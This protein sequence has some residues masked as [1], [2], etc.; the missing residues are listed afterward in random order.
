M[1]A[2]LVLMALLPQDSYLPLKQGQQ[3]TYVVQDVG[4]EAS[5]PAREVVAEVGTPDADPAWVPVSNYLGYRSCWLRSGREGIELK[6][7]AKAD[8][9]ALTILKDSA[10]TGDTWTGTLG[11]EQLTFSL[12]GEDTLER[13]ETRVRALH[14][15]FTASKEKHAGHAATHGDVWFAA[16][17][18]IVRAQVTTDLDCHTAMSKVYELKP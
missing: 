1:R 17:V 2:M 10:K 3:W 7:D 16:G 14:V 6:L 5:D 15:E 4:A 11:K 18:G 8:A 12:R 9:P 13:G